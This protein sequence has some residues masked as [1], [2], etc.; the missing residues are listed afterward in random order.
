M[1]KWFLKSKKF[2]TDGR[3][4]FTLEY[5]KQILLYNR[6]IIGDDKKEEFFDSNIDRIHSPKLFKESEKF[7]EI[8]ENVKNNNQKI[9]IV[10]D[11]DVDGITST[12]ILIKLFNRLNIRNIYIIPNRILDGYGINRR[13]VDFAINNNCD[14]IMT[15]DNGILAFDAIDYA[16]DNGL[17]VIVTDH[18]EPYVE[19]D[20][21]IRPNADVVIDPKND[22]DNYPF[23]YL[24]G[25]GVCLK[26]AKLLFTYYNIIDYELMDELEVLAGIAT[27]CDVVDLIDENRVLAVN[28]LKKIQYNKN[29]AL[30]NLLEKNNISKDKVNS[31]HIGFIIGP[32]F[33]AIGRL[34]D[35]NFG[36]E[37]L[38]E[39]DI[40]KISKMSDFINEL[41]EKRKTITQK[42]YDL[43]FDRINNSHLPDI[44]VEYLEDV[45][46]SVAGIIA[47]KIKENFYRPTLIIT[48][49]N[50]EFKG[51]GRSVDGFNIYQSLL[52]NKDLLTKFGGHELACGFSMTPENYNFFKAYFDNISLS[53]EVLTKKIFIDL[54]LPIE[55]IDHNILSLINEFKPFGKGN[56][57]V[58]FAD[59]SLT[60]L[61]LKVLGKNSN[62]L[63]FTVKT[64]NGNIKKLVYFIDFNEFKKNIT[65]E[66]GNINIIGSKMDIVYY[67]EENIY[68][69]NVYLN[70]IIKHLRLSEVN[71]D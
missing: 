27:I 13:C 6:N 12:T 25:A 36:V 16:K 15:C 49:S 41:N 59:K 20:I 47:G 51:S 52:A 54:F 7:L 23:K 56:D 10:G 33:N 32:R 58:L 14:V 18:H 39:T 8:I 48:K 1:E 5:I 57:E 68:N 50:N 3:S 45:H 26:L 61:D 63:N 70:F 69:G 65:K 40:E 29:L 43:V 2:N 28:A 67:P 60:I 4:P 46:E 11:Y 44:I 34:D 38:L 37:F 64:S 21:Q 30:N 62:V 22:Y 55:Y 24:C 9:C 19:N 66:Y 42:G 31:Y 35:A 17:T 71:Y 53:D